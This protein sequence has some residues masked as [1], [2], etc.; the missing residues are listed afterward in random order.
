[1]HK[2]VWNDADGTIVR[3]NEWI[4]TQQDSK[5]YI[6]TLNQSDGDGAKEAN[7]WHASSLYAF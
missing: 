7:C 4:E 6:I 5:T 1:M 3:V 2:Q